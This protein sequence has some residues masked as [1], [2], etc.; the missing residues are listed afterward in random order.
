MA[1]PTPAVYAPALTSDRLQ[2]VAN[3]LLDE[4]QATE[5]DL[6]R[7]TDTRWTKGCTTFGR[8]H[9]RIV[10]EWKSRNHPWLGMLDASNALVF[11]I[12]EVPCRFSNDDP[13]NP[14]KKAVL[15]INPYQRAFAEFFSPELPVRYC[16]VVDRGMDGLADPYV[17]LH[18]LSDSNQIVCRWVSDSVPAFR[19]ETENKPDAVDVQKRPLSARQPGEV[20]DE[21]GQQRTEDGDT[22]ESV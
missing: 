16:F 19:V 13:D 9:S 8:Q 17:V 4:L 20:S 12:G 15:E 11:T 14:S 1:L 5:D 7:A 21:Q 22:S 2:M 18:G 3:W 10:A 6:I